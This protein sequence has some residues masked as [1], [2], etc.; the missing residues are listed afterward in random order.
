M[1]LRS[2]KSP[3][4]GPGPPPKGVSRALWPEPSGPRTDPQPLP[5]RA[6]YRPR[7]RVDVDFTMPFRRWFPAGVLVTL[8][9][10][11]ELAATFR[12]HPDWFTLVDAKPN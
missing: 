5:P 8:D 12:E 11:P 2:K 3:H 7:Y 4:R 9:D 6:P 1:S 10:D